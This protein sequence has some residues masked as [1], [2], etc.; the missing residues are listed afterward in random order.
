MAINSV[1]ERYKEIKYPVLMISSGEKEVV[2]LITDD[3]GY[4]FVVSSNDTALPVGMAGCWYLN[5]LKKFDG[6]IILEN[7]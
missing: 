2:L 3:K 1:I 6:K 5:D 7:E 4:G